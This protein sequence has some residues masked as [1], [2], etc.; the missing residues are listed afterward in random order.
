MPRNNKGLLCFF[1]CF[2]FQFFNLNQE[3][4]LCMMFWIFRSGLVTNHLTIAH[5]PSSRGA[6]G[7]IVAR[8]SFPST[9]KFNSAQVING[10]QYTGLVDQESALIVKVELHFY[11]TIFHSYNSELMLV[12]TWTSNLTW[13]Y[14]NTFRGPF[15]GNVLR[16]Y[17]K[18][19]LS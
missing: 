16:G 7:N 10:P 14:N 13:K 18:T 1:S 11:A 17:L 8:W 4:V 9:L 3:L 2:S 5:K 19:D 6:A 12:L 15:N